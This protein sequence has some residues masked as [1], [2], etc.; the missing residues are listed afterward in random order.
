MAR[1]EQGRQ[2]G[3]WNQARE[4]PGGPGRRPALASQAGMILCPPA[5]ARFPLPAM[6]IS[7]CLATS[8]GQLSCC[9]PLGHA[10]A[11]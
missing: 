5:P 10:L 6:P 7:R 4:P 9:P 1:P 8:A 3:S 2:A 11:M